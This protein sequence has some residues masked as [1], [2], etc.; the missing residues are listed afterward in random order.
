MRDSSFPKSQRI[1]KREASSTFNPSL[2]SHFH[3]I[4]T[5]FYFSV[6]HFISHSQTKE[7]SSL[8]WV[9][10]FLFILDTACTNQC[11][12]AE[13]LLNILFSRLSQVKQREGLYDGK[14]LQAA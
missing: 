1:S 14:A 12:N 6:F 2:Q 9:S 4:S 13:G 5:Q 3:F 11:Q 8:P 7:P 10:H